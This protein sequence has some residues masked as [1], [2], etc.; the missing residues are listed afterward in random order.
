M[1]V[2]VGLL[3][4]GTTWD[5]ATPARPLWPLLF[6][7]G[8]AVLGL[9]VFVIAMAR[10]DWLPGRTAA[11]RDEEKRHQK[12]IELESRKEG[13]RRMRG[14]FSPAAPDHDQQRHTEALNR[15]SDELRLQREA[16][17]DQSGGGRE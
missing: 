17:D 8:F 6:I 11:E 5:T 4:V 14:F 12:E 13:A 7:F 15:H 9:V 2:F 16:G 3:G 1:V 10:P